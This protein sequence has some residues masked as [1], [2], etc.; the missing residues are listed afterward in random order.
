MGQCKRPHTT[1]FVSETKV[2]A[3][4]WQFVMHDTINCPDVLRWRMDDL[5]RKTTRVRSPQ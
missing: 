3:L 2:T 1:D 4:G 5:R